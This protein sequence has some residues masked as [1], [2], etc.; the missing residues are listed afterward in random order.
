MKGFKQFNKKNHESLR[1]SA[2]H[3]KQ[4]NKHSFHSHGHTKKNHITFFKKQIKRIT[5]VSHKN[6]Y[7][8][9]QLT[10]SSPQAR[11]QCSADS[12]S[13]PLDTGHRCRG[14]SFAGCRLV[15]V[16]AASPIAVTG[17]ESGDYGFR[18]VWTESWPDNTKSKILKIPSL[19]CI[20]WGHFQNFH[21]VTVAARKSNPDPTPLRPSSL[22]MGAAPL[23]S[24]AIAAVTPA[25]N[26]YAH[27]KL[28]KTRK[29][30]TA[31]MGTFATNLLLALTIANS[32]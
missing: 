6:C 7:R 23:R 17:L 11:W 19:S 20:K 25:I 31:V 28:L 3:T 2:G 32:I 21:G 14:R 27:N 29:E 26:N 16:L 30:V 12:S 22:W 4:F 18:T 24:A 5:V 10:S 8:G 9:Q 1:R 15:V 13:G